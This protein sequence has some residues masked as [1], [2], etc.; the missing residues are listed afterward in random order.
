MI[1]RTGIVVF[2]RMEI[3]GET[4][5]IFNLTIAAVHF[6]VTFGTQEPGRLMFAICS[7]HSTE[8]NPLQLT[9]NEKTN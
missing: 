3:T 2:R 4:V 9:K 7:R 8:G 6:V 5:P 1:K